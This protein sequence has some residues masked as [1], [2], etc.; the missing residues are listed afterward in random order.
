MDCGEKMETVAAGIGRKHWAIA[1]GHIPGQSQGP[2]P[3]MLSH[4]TAGGERAAIDHG[5]SG[6][7][8]N[9]SLSF[10]LFDF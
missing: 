5:L 9:G 3:A 4:E 6:R 8:L 7:G 10:A 1:E 2:E